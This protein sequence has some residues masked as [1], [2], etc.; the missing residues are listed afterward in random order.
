MIDLN[1]LFYV[2]VQADGSCD[3]DVLLASHLTFEQ[4]VAMCNERR[5]W[6]F[7]VGGFW[8]FNVG[9]RRQMI[10]EGQCRISVGGGIARDTGWYNTDEYSNLIKQGRI[11]TWRESNV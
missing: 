5:F 3:T 6:G 9:R 11:H 10:F 2:V 1:G 4:A 8:G 7:N